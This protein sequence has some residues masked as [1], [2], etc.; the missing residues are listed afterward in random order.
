MTDDL[1]TDLRSLLSGLD[2]LREDELAHVLEIGRSQ[3][4]AERIAATPWRRPRRPRT[5]AFGLA[6]AAA[7]AASIAAAAIAVSLTS[8]STP[9]AYALSFSERGGYVIARIVN[10]Y[11]SVS[12]LRRELAKNHL[13]VALHLLPVSPAL[14]G[15]VVALDVNGKPTNGIQPLF[16]GH[17][18]KGHCVNGP[19]TV[20][21]KVARDFK[22]SGAIYI[23]RPARGSERYGVT[24]TGGAFAAG[25]ALHCSGLQG[26]Q[27]GRLLPALH[28][29][30][31]KVVRWRVVGSHPKAGAAAPVDARVEEVMPVAPGQV[32]LWVATASQGK[33]SAPG[34][35]PLEQC[36][37]VA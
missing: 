31:L 25:E 35:H 23:G 32:E 20:G 3:G 12:E 10:P 21:V 13:H 37:G 19:C 24:P 5:R 16:D 6:A 26:A 30:G 8:S 4:G 11:A 28:S 22:G 2:P 1:S 18:S 7:V 27:V 15:K 36:P 17:S 34:H 33:Q 29:K 9:T 14:V